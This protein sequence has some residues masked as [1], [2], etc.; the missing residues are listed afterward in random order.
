MNLIK[1]LIL[2]LYNIIYFGFEEWVNAGF[3]LALVVVT[4]LTYFLKNRRKYSNKCACVIIFINYFI[5]Y[6]SFLIIHII[7]GCIPHGW[8]LSILRIFYYFI[9][10]IMVYFITNNF[11]LKYLEDINKQAMVT[12]W[13]YKNILLGERIIFLLLLIPIVVISKYVYPLSDDYCFGYLVHQSW[14]HKHSMID[15]ILMACRQ[16]KIAY[17]GWQGTFSSIFLMALQPAVFSVKLYHL[18]PIFFIGVLSLTSYILLNTLLVHTLKMNKTYAKIIMLTYILYIIQFIPAKATAFFWFNGAIHYLFAYCIF[19][20]LANSYINLYIGRNTKINLGLGIFSALYLGGANYVVLFATV[21]FIITALSI[22]FVKKQVI[23]YYRILIIAVVF[24]ISSLINILAPGNFAKY[25][26]TKGI[27]FFASVFGAFKEGTHYMFGEWM[28]W[29]LIAVLLFLIP[30]LWHAVNKL[31]FPFS[32]PGLISAYSFCFISSMFAF[33]L[34]SLGTVNVGRFLN[35]IYLLYVLLLMINV[36]YWIGWIQKKNLIKLLD[37]N[38]YISINEIKYYVALFICIFVAT[39]LSWYA[40]PNQ[41]TST[42]AFN[43]LAKGEASEY[44]RTYEE[45][46]SHLSTTKDRNVIIKDLPYEPELF[47]S[48]EMEKWNMG[49]KLF[50]DKDEVIISED[51]L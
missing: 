36:G 45:N 23:K 37:S 51:G 40:E 39:I 25:E 9:S 31:E 16:V 41:M 48:E 3:I 35:V 27:G 11:V 8:V 4:V 10:I 28:H 21:L 18:I 46:L 6:L 1:Q 15:A 29:S 13:Q 20:L 7:Y 49:L 32:Y 34:F 38:G 5:L 47:I 42:L 14:I 33:P 2:P 12:K 24:S 43:T 22:L 17:L 26:L 19:L 50:F 44:G 30:V